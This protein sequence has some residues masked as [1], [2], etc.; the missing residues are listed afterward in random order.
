[1]VSDLAA[2]PSN[3][4]ESK[5]ETFR[6]LRGRER[7]AFFR[8]PFLGWRLLAVGIV[9]LVVAIVV[10]MLNP[11]PQ[12]RLEIMVMDMVEDSQS[13]DAMSEEFAKAAGADP[14]T[15]YFDSTYTSSSSYTDG[16]DAKLSTQYYMGNLTAIIAP[17]DAFQTIV[18]RGMIVPLDEAL[19]KDEAAKLADDAQEFDSPTKSDEDDSI[20][21]DGEPY[22]YGLNLS[23]SSTWTGRFGT[24]EPNG[25]M[26][27]GFVR[28]AHTTDLIGALID[29]LAFE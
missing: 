2:A 27:L 17:K 10:H 5:I 28:D 14:D 4:E 24:D 29:Y 11:A 26:Y 15:I 19:G 9:A 21:T 23:H 7:W 20:T 25:D 12:M 8:A 22:A 13:I 3:A 6:R 1:M 18:S 16:S